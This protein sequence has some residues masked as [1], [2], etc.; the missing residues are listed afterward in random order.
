MIGINDTHGQQLL[1]MCK[2]TQVTI[3]N[4]RTRGDHT[5]KLTRFPLSLRETASTIDSMLADRESN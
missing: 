3:L 1:N 4:G 2:N 5:G